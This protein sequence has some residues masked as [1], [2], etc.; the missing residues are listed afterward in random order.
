MKQEKIKEF[1]DELYFGQYGLEDLKGLHMI[2]SSHLPKHLEQMIKRMDRLFTKY[3]SHSPI[4]FGVCNTFTNEKTQGDKKVCKHGSFTCGLRQ[5]L[6]KE[7]GLSKDARLCN[8]CEK[9]KLNQNTPSSKK[10]S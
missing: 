7:G 3:T 1:R 4:M 5:A 8:S 6:I 2:K 9:D 10:E